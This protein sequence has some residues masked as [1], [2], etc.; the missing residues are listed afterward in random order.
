MVTRLETGIEVLDRKLDGGVPAG[1]IVA[2]S[3]QPA[4]QAELIL[5]ELTAARGTL[6][7]S[8]NRTADAV[9]ESIA[10]TRAETGDPTVQYISGDAPLDNAGKLVSALPE[11]SNLVVDPVDVLESRESPSRFRNFLNDLH[12]HVVNTGSLAILH[13][14]DGHSVPPLR[15][16]TE[17][18][19]DVIFRV[20]TDLS[21]DEVENRLSVPKF[22]GGRA[23]TETLKL[24]LVDRVDVDTTRDIA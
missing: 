6:W 15:D 21:G 9:A 17:H 20:E 23:P 7:L 2:L 19:A 10:D 8:L 24:D 5:Y 14:L 4:S 3:A 13:C 22:R 11:R 18:F 16:T 12:N 1:S